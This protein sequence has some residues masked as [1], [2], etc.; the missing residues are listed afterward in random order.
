VGT[1]IDGEIPDRDTSA[2]RERETGWLYSL[3]GVVLAVGLYSALH[4]T[5]R[6]IASG[7]LGEDDPLDAILTQSLQLGYRP[8]Q[9]PLYDWMLWLLQRVFGLG[10]LPYQLLKYTLLTATCGFIFL[11]ARRVMKGDAFWAFL[12]VEALA[13]IYQISWRFHEGFTH[14]VGAMCAVAAAFWAMLGLIERQRP[15]DYLLLG[16]ILGLGVLTVPTFWAYIAALFGAS[17]LQPAMRSVLLR[18]QLALTALVA[19]AIAAPH[20]IWL[21]QTPEGISAIL[22]SFIA[23][24]PQD[25]LI[26]AISGIRRAFTEPVMYL[27]PLILLYPLFFPAMIGTIRRCISLTPNQNAR[28]DF[29]QLLLHLTVLSIGVLIAAALLFG[30]YRY[31]VHALMPL[32]LM[33]SIWFTAQARKAAPSSRQVRRF[34][35]MALSVAIFAFFARAANMYVLQ[36]VCSICRWGIPYTELAAEMKQRGLDARRILVNDRELGGNLRRFFPDSIIALTG[37]RY[38]VPPLFE[39]GNSSQAKITVLWASELSIE[40]AA[41]E[42]QRVLPAITPVK[43]QEAA[44]ISIPWK[45]FFWVPYGDPI[46]IWRVVVLTAP[47]V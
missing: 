35:V 46:S 31:P 3:G 20:F 15:A 40:K 21:A 41:A 27:A 23:S 43:L 6:L 33:T 4:I 32:F 7:N 24:N 12:S 39:T 17:V 34:V 13:L 1:A 10:V 38:Y 36:P 8:D 16:V 22:P 26:Y 45:G 9:P 19:A 25:Y 28:P 37:S 11:A 29:E 30:I 5:A 42:F 14:A 18:G 2:A 44:T 47:S